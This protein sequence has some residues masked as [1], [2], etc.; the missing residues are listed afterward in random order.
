MLRLESIAVGPAGNRGWR[1]MPLSR[2]V[3]SL[4]M[5]M[6]SHIAL[7]ALQLAHTPKCKRRSRRVHCLNIN[8]RGIVP[9]AATAGMS[10]LARVC[11]LRRV[12]ALR[13]CQFSVTV[14][15]AAAAALLFMCSPVH[16]VVL[17]QASPFAAETSV[18]RLFLH[19]HRSVRNRIRAVRIDDKR[20]L[21]RFLTRSCC[22][23]GKL[24][25]CSCAQMSSPAATCGL[26]RQELKEMGLVKDPVAFRCPMPVKSAAGGADMV[27]NA[28]FTSHSA[29]AG[30]AGSFP[31]SPARH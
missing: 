14:C 22:C 24:V 31:H 27:C 5:L 11:L 6:L 4:L 30:A 10:S 28:L 18:S 13:C 17:A 16:I 29:A 2:P 25:C 3:V 7:S 12:W 19:Y 23:H 8:C 26:T 9:L 1:R 20:H 15:P 21:Y